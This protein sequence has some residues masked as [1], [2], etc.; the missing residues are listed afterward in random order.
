MGDN[1]LGQQSLVAVSQPAEA[2]SE[3]DRVIFMDEFSLQRHPRSTRQMHFE[4]DD[5]A[6][7]PSLHHTINEA[8]IHADLAHAGVLFSRRTLPDNIQRHGYGFV[9]SS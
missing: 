1:N 6:Q 5:V 2:Q 8:A 3:A 7:R 9:L 4:F